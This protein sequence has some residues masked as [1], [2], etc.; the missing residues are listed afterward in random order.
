MLLRQI[1]MLITLLAITY[2]AAA[3]GAVGSMSAPSFYQQLQLPA[4][5]PPGWL[6]GP[7]WTVLYTLMALASWL[8]WRKIGIKA[9][10]LQAL[11]I[12]HLAV[13]A[14][15]SWC[16]FAWQQGALA[17]VNIAMLWIMIAALL[18]G[19]WRH[20]RVAA[21]LLVPYLLWVSFAMWL[22]FQLWQ[23]NPGLL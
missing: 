7:V 3:L 10:P 13:N 12:V 19:Y 22:N 6:F 9:R 11:Y 1:I 5:A 4:L 17:L 8:V 20:H 2:F 21:L 18:L 23:L 14:S 16:F 15:W